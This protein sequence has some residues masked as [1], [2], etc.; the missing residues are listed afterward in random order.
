MVSEIADISAT[1]DLPLPPLFSSDPSQ[2]A[3]N[4]AILETMVRKGAWKAAEVLCEV[5]MIEGGCHS[6]RADMTVVSR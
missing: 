2:R 6:Y 1:Y 5:S 4:G 3:M